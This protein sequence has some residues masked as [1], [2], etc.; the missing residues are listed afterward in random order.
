[1]LHVQKVKVGEQDLLCDFSTSVM[2]PL[3]PVSFR[4][5]V[6]DSIHQ[7]A[8]AGTCTTHRLISA[9]FVWR[10]MAGD[11]GEWCK[12]CVGCARGKTLVHVK[13]PVQQIPVPAARFDHVHVDIVR[14]FPT[15][16]EGFQYVL[17]MID[18][19]SKWPEVIP[20]GSIRAS[21]CADA[22]TA[23]WVARFGVP[24]AVTTDRGT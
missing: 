13:S 14:P 4:K 24:A 23:G 10:G 19:M 17:T 2:R 20:L 11:I 12:D 18:R 16:A 15:T 3:V 7:L 8:H 9:P 21:E 5:K 22:F 6:F 1:M